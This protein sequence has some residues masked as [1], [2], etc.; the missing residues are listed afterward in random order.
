MSRDKIHILLLMA[1][2][3]MMTLA[4]ASC[5]KEPNQTATAADR[6]MIVYLGGDNNLSGESFQKLDALQLVV[7]QNPIFTDGSPSSILVYHDPATASGAKPSL[8]RLR[9]GH[10][11]PQLIEQYDTENSA[12]AEVF[13]RVIK[14][15]VTI[16]PAKSYGLWLFSHASGWLP[17]GTLTNPKSKSVV[18]DG[19]NEMEIA[20]LAAAIPQR[21]FDF[22]VFEACFMA[23][24]EVAHEL[25][26]KTDYILASSAEILSPGFTDLYARVIP[27]LFNPNTQSNTLP[28]LTYAA[29]T[30]F[31]LRDAQGGIEKSATISIVDTK[32]LDALAAVVRDIVCQTN[33]PPDITQIQHFDRHQSHHLFF[34]LNHYLESFAQTPSQQQQLAAALT[35][36]VPY[37]QATQEFMNYTGYN[38]FE[39]REHCGLTTYIE[40]QK[41]PI[42]NIAHKQT[43]WYNAIY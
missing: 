9:H 42:L 8:W 35:A 29:Q 17:R 30:F 41:M 21:M 36:A 39:I 40:Q 2:S 13:E 7:S 1:L 38:G 19:P 32:H 20:D 16:A 6:T 25:K 33:D 23:S 4:V 14:T 34:D 15:C 43:S 37:K 22:I 31:K 5:S 3:L 28:A 10:T 18:V 26:T 11:L 24:V 12:S 27:P